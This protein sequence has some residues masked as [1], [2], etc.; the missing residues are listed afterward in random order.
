MKFFL[1]FR[2]AVF[3]SLLSRFYH[4][5]AF[6]VAPSD[7]TIIRRTLKSTRTTVTS[8][9]YA[10]TTTPSGSGGSSE[11]RTRTTDTQA[12][13]DNTAERRTKQQIAIVGSGAVGCYYGCRLWEVGY[14]V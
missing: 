12:D 7:S 13:T 8:A 6:H 10:S 2:N 3:L 11:T 4:C 1:S 14:D 9:L 5:L